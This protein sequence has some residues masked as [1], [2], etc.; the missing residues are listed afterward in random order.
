MTID[1]STLSKSY[2]GD[3]STTAFPAT[4]EF[5]TESDLKV[6]LRSSAGIETVQTLST[7]YTVSEPSPA[8]G[9]GTVNMITPP[10]V[11]ETLTIAL[12]VPYTQQTDLSQQ[13]ALPA[14]VIESGID[15]VVL[16][17]KQ[18]AEQIGRAVLTKASSNIGQLVFPDPVA[19]KAVT[20]DSS[21]EIALV[22]F[23]EIDITVTNPVLAGVALGD[24][25]YNNGTNWVNRNIPD[26]SQAEAEAGTVTAPRITTPQRQKQAIEALTSINAVSFPERLQV[27]RPSTSTLRL[28]AKRVFLRDA[29][30]KLHVAENVDVTVDITA[31]GAN[32]LDTGSEGS[33]TFYQVQ[34]I[35]NGSVIAGVLSKLEKETGAATS[36]TANKLVD[37]GASFTC[38]VGDVVTNTT[39]DA[40][41]TVTAVDSGTSLSLADDIFAIGENYVISHNKP[42]MPSGY[43]HWSDPVA[44]WLNGSG[45]DFLPGLQYGKNY[46]YTGAL[47][48][49]IEYFASAFNQA[50]FTATSIASVCPTRSGQVATV[51]L[52]GESNVTGGE[53]LPV[54]ID[55]TNTVGTIRLDLTPSVGSSAHPGDLDT[56]TI[57]APNVD[58]YFIKSDLGRSSDL[59]VTG[60]VLS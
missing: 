27:T 54:S 53:I 21:G 31:S 48:T 40:R 38:Q 49:G 23:S 26:M 16:Q 51:A 20:I 30:S 2:S 41:T 19:N 59:A 17:T 33:S 43:T 6:I 12:D 34:F 29:N 3:G 11:G 37:S 52:G 47:G 15:K 44:F 50:S 56:G 45:S 9:V 55:G 35:Y 60:W 46:Q 36:T 18:L 28:K 8:P 5:F 32:G 42:V 58:K 39:D 24:Y 25:L 14:E 10:A 22:D 4:F 1:S 57:L 13:S 7:H